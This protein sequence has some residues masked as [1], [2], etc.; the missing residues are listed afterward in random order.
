MTKQQATE[1]GEDREVEPVLI[2][3]YANRRL[4]DTESS[5][6]VKLA[7]LADMAREGREFTVQDARTGEDITRSVL[8][9]IILESENRGENLLPLGFLRGIAGLYGDAMRWSVPGYLESTMSVLHRHQEALRQQM[10][11]AL[12]SGA[13]AGFDQ[14]ARANQQMFERTMQMFAPFAG[15]AGDASDSASRDGESGV[16]ADS[17]S[18]AI[19]ELRR[20]VEAMQERL[21]EITGKE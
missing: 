8:V 18:K 6:Y 1:G 17:E 14:A 11:G 5:A 2:K 19:A 20:Q 13:V 12:G 9:Q 15:V 3:K 10:Q 16:R 21:D 7:D 4:Y